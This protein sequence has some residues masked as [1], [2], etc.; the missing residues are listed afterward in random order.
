MTDHDFKGAAK[1]LTDADRCDCFQTGLA[2]I[3]AELLARQV[4]MDTEMQKI[5]VADIEELYEP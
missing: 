1:R 3:Y 5:I 2:G 4:P